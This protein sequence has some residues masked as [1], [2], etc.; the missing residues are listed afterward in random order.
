MSADR[1]PDGRY[2]PGHGIP[3]P[4]RPRRAVEADYLRVF[5]DVV[6]LEDLKAIVAVVRT[7]AL[8]G[9]RW[10]CELLMGRLLGPPAADQLLNLAASEWS[11]FDPVRDRATELSHRVLFDDLVSKI[12]SGP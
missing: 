3:G 2:L 4:G 1:A 7:K 9:E 10:A 12:A 8:A 6:P 11:G 5:S